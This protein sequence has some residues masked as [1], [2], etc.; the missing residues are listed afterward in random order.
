MIKNAQG[1]YKD[2]WVI[3]P[4][5]FYIENDALGYIED[6]FKE[7]NNSLMND[8]L[9]VWRWRDSDISKKK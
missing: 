8:Q 5:S 4:R 2:V 6:N 9:K 1:K 7:I 3:F